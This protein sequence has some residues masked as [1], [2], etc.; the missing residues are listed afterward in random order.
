M[1]AE[2]TE[3]KVH[4]RQRPVRLLPP[5]DVRLNHILPEDLNSTILTGHQI[6]NPAKDSNSRAFGK[7]HLQSQTENIILPVHCVL[8]SPSLCP[9]GLINH[10]K[11]L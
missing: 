2:Y 9:V 11:N 7:T 6:V 8:Y 4:P 5:S 10:L 1:T 3:K